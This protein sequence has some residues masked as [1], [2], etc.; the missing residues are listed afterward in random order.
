MKRTIGVIFGGRSAEH[1]VSI[2][3]AKTVVKNLRL[4]G[5]AVKPI[6]IPQ[7]GACPALLAAKQKPVAACLDRSAKMSIQ[8]SGAWLLV[9]PEA[10]A[11]GGN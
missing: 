3:S 2:E 1:E 5:Y 8:K 10:L 6:Y 9:A 4:A 7:R 11:K